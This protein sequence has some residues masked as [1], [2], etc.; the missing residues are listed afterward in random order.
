MTPDIYIYIYEKI[1]KN[2]QSSGIDFIMKNNSMKIYKR[3][4]FKFY[5]IK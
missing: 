1:S 2:S 3:I 4:E 5:W